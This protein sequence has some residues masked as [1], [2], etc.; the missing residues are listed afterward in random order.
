MMHSVHFLIM[1]NKLSKTCCVSSQQ[2]NSVIQH[3]G[4]DVKMHPDP[5]APD[6]RGPHAIAQLS[7]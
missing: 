2:A 6:D 4:A 1:Y 5:G 7:L 3:D